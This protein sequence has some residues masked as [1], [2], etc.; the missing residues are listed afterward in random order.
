MP[1]L[2]VAMC[3]I[4][5]DSTS[6][7]FE[8]ICEVPKYALS[9]TTYGENYEE[10]ET[11]DFPVMFQSETDAES[12]TLPA[13]SGNLEEYEI[14]D[15]KDLHKVSSFVEI[16]NAKF[17]VKND[18]LNSNDGDMIRV[19]LLDN[20]KNIGVGTKIYFNKISVDE[21]YL[22]VQTELSGY[23]FNSEDDRFVV[24]RHKLL[25]NVLPHS[26]SGPSGC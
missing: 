24:Y 1:K 15:L 20:A 14:L 25:R 19:E 22:T 3:P 26:V 7:S 8:F 12:D 23:S 5:M 13:T 18:I 11:V 6:D 9:A 10:Y 21:T 16:D 4:R 17:F 2:S